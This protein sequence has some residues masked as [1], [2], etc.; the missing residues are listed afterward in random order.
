MEDAS[1]PGAKGQRRRRPQKTAPPRWDDREDIS[2]FKLA[3]KKFRR[4]KGVQTDFSAAIDVSSLGGGA[5]AV[6][7][8]GHDGLYVLPG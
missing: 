6:A 3:E 8:D 1:A 2:P 4:Y 7:V 5:V